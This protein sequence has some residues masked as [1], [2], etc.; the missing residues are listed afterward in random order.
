MIQ[1]MNKG[2]LMDFTSEEQRKEKR[3]T[4][5]FPAQVCW[6]DH[7]GREITDQAFTLNVSGS[8]ISLQTN[9]RV[10][11]GKRVKVTLD[12]DGL[13]GSSFAE[14]K[15]LERAYPGYRIGVSFKRMKD[16]PA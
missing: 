3:V 14:V 16:S 13:T 4:I 8:G 12:I 2:Q 6:L 5:Q 15:W 7:L 11:E 10:S 9:Q 1:V